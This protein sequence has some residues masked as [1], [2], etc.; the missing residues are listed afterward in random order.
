MMI[1]ND[2]FLKE[3]FKPSKESIY[4]I[5]D[6]NDNVSLIGITMSKRKAKR[7]KN[8]YFK[9]VYKNFD[10]N[11]IIVYEYKVYGHKII[12]YKKGL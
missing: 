10:Y 6:W 11:P 5:L 4:V 3:T 8:K 7:I 12:F 1:V 9:R 2:E